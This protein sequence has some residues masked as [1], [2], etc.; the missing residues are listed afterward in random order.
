M[1]QKQRL[2]MLAYEESDFIQFNSLLLD[3]KNSFT[4]NGPKIHS[5]PQFI[6][7]LLSL[8]QQNSDIQVECCQVLARIISNA[9][10]IAELLDN[11]SI[12]II[13]NLFLNSTTNFQFLIFLTILNNI[14]VN[15]PD[16]IPEFDSCYLHLVQNFDQ[17]NP[18]DVITLFINNY[19][20]NINDKHV[21]QEKLLE[22][23]N[24][25]Q[26]IF[27]QSIN[28]IISLYIDVLHDNPEY[29]TLFI[30]NSII[31]HYSRNFNLFLPETQSFIL[32][33]FCHCIICEITMGIDE[34]IIEN[35]Q[36]IIFDFIPS[37]NETKSKELL[38]CI[39]VICVMSEEFSHVITNDFLESLIESSDSQILIDKIYRI[40]IRLA[41][42]NSLHENLIQKNIIE[43][44]V[45]SIDVLQET[46]VITSSLV[47]LQHL[48]NN[49]S[50]SS[51][52]DLESFSSKSDWFYSFN[53]EEISTLFDSIS[54]SN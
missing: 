11:A 36:K 8:I 54:D 4:I 23:F 39:E 31:T 38:D 52:F 5:T 41:N 48:M 15:I 3:F 30:E 32:S 12:E 18:K 34:V 28:S 22:I 35:I 7:F 16:K 17:I 40:I 25:T 6:M 42:F 10:D 29:I 13:V 9:N 47:L 46:D 50:F 43:F 19:V 49:N 27:D 51:H 2:I 20:H 33:F 37:F 1:I 14:I 26:N 45:D 44:I 24:L 21:Q 53:N